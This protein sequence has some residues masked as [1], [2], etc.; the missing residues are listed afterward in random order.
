[1]G[2]SIIKIKHQNTRLGFCQAK[3]TAIIQ[4]ISVFKSIE[5]KMKSLN[6]RIY[7][8]LKYKLTYIKASMCA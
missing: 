7:L 2:F 3:L 6:L 8:I 1:V 5:E 4:F